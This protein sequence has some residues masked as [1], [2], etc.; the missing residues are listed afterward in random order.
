MRKGIYL[1]LVAIS[2]FACTKPANIDILPS[3]TDSPD[4]PLPPSS[5][6]PGFGNSKSRPEGIPVIFPS[7]ITVV[8]KPGF[9]EDCYHDARNQKMIK[10]SGNA[11]GFC[12]TFSNTNAYPVRIE[13]P[14]GIIWVA[15]TNEITQDISQNGLIVK[16]VSVLVPAHAVERTWLLAYCINAD[17]SG[18]HTGDTFNAQPILS[19]HPGVKALV[20]Q[21]A[22]KKIN[23][24][25]YTHEATQ[26]EQAQLAFVGVAVVDIQYYGEVQ[27]STQPYLDK[28]PDSK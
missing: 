24:E 17:R 3:S 4:D 14:P 23:A 13:L 20:K 28:L 10:G 21:L 9:D 22:S 8:G 6:A 26:A 12:L 11:V 18:T 15:E 19:N 27:A 16:T 25:E 1:L 2:L 7:G 5:S